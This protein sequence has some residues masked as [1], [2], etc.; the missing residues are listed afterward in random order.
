M[1]NIFISSK[2]LIKALL[3]KIEVA[4]S[5]IILVILY[6]AFDNFEVFARSFQYRLGY[7]AD[8]LSTRRLERAVFYLPQAGALWILGARPK[9]CLRFLAISG[10][11]FYAVMILWGSGT[12]CLRNYELIMFLSVAGT[13]A[14]FL[15]FWESKSS[16]PAQSAPG[17]GPF[18]R[19]GYA[20][21]CAAAAVFAWAL[22]SKPLEHSAFREVISQGVWE[23]DTG[24]YAG[25]S[26][27]AFA[28]IPWFAARRRGRRGPLLTAT[29]ALASIFGAAVMFL[30]YALGAKAWQIEPI[31][32]SWMLCPVWMAA[33]LR[34]GPGKAK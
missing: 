5:I 13:L 25:L 29:S 23:A 17:A 9:I 32:F 11:G 30:P 3:P 26:V 16:V 20:A 31:T 18:K 28:A 14:A 2:D 7:C 24:L 4:A 19:A 27:L 15:G 8:W 12:A 34:W 33:L 6:A 1:S 22:C 10:V 21:A